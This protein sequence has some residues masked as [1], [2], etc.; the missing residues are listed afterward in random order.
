MDEPEIITL[1]AMETAVPQRKLSLS[2]GAVYVVLIVLVI[3]AISLAN[4]IYK[5]WQIPQYYVQPALYG[6]IAIG[7][8]YAYRRHFLSYR[9]T[10]TDAMFA[11]ERVAG[12]RGH[13]IAAM[14]LY[15]ILDIFPNQDCKRAKTQVIHAS[16]PPKNETTCVVTVEN[17]KEKCYRV[18]VST[19]LKQQLIV[20][21]HLVKAQKER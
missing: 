17:G 1:I 18:S 2:A 4:M 20:Q 15:D 11:I 6:L 7:G 13:T 9:Y 21:W 8:L 10:L 3:G 19:E 12:E 14:M 5:Q 16:L